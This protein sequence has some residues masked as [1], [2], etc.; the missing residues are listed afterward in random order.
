MNKIKKVLCLVLVVVMC[1]TSIPS[2]VFAN[3]EWFFKAS[4]A[5][6]TAGY[7]TYSV[8]ENEAKITNVDDSIAG[9]VIVPSFLGGY[10]V[11]KIGDYA[12]DDCHEIES[13]VIPGTVISLYNW[14]FSN[15]NNL[16]YVVMCDGVETIGD[17]A[18]IDCDDLVSVVIPDSIKTIYNLAFYDSPSI[19]NVYYTGTQSQW[20]EVKIASFNSCLTRAE[21]HCNYYN[22]YD[23][24][25]GKE[26]N[27]DSRIPD[28]NAKFTIHTFASQPKL[29]MGYGDAMTMKFELECHNVDTGE[30]FLV[31]N[32]T[33]ALSSSDTD[34]FT[35]ENI[36]K[37]GQTTSARL[38]SENPGNAILTVGAYANGKLVESLQ[39]LIAVEGEC[40]Y[41]IDTLINGKGDKDYNLYSYSNGIHIDNLEYVETGAECN[42]SFDVYNSVNCIAAVEVYAADGELLA[43]KSI[44]AFGGTL[45]TGIFDTFKQM[46]EFAG[47]DYSN[48]SYKDKEY[49]TKTEVTLIG[50]PTDGHIKITTD[51]EDS[52][53]CAFYNISDLL[54]D[55]ALKIADLV[56]ETEEVRKKATEDLTDKILE[57][58]LSD[59]NLKKVFEEIIRKYFQSIKIGSKEEIRDSLEEYVI[60][61]EELDID[62]GEIILDT[63]KGMGI[64]VVETAIGFLLGPVKG[65]VETIFAVISFSKLIDHGVTVEELRG[66]RGSAIYFKRYASAIRYSNGYHINNSE[67]FPDD[68]SFHTYKI[69][70]G[71]TYNIATSNFADATYIDVISMALYKDGK[72]T[73]PNGSVQVAI[74]IPDGMNIFSFKVYRQEPDGSFEQLDCDFSNVNGGYIYI[75]TDHFSVYC[76]VG[77]II[78]PE[79]I[80]FENDEYSVE[81]GKGLIPQPKF[82]PENAYAVN[83]SVTSSN[84]NIAKVSDSGMIVGKE[85]GKAVITVIAENGISSTFV[86]NV[87]PEPC[88][89]H[90]YGDK[91]AICKN[92]GFD[93]TEGC[94]CNCHKG[95]ISGFFFKII[96]FFQKLFKSN[97]ICKCG[98]KHY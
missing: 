19:E 76:I 49:S 14:S 56:F 59:D 89:D 97:Q 6:Y 41:H 40:V 20:S 3:F 54:V 17:A 36:E 75:T 21:L 12:F 83:Y 15:C 73:Q 74:P 34:V 87:V 23:E 16:K 31:S 33:F 63:L 42:L 93:R 51:I 2:S 9:N 92:C 96:L 64:S 70:S 5:K 72:E 90:I 62:I 60:G 95:G 37:D 29:I 46:Y 8:S 35:V 91:D 57:K 22:K 30:N 98:I 50:V 48:I 44:S 18:F 71:D 39:Y 68:V 13:V 4:A 28:D 65:F 53:A 7:Y 11:T 47:K 80:Y 55:S 84:E 67:P 32:P 1:L 88:I 94:S 85:K 52:W 66:S 86:V 58:V 24:L 10:P 77:D 26:A 27:T 43:T 69:L 81:V 78:E 61:L 45:P 38:V 82:S 79:S 25:F